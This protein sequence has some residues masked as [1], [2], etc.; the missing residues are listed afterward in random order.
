MIRDDFTQTVDAAAGFERLRALN[1]GSYDL[2][3]ERPSKAEAD[4]D[5]AWVRGQRGAW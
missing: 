5:E 4:R 2:R 1:E 3:D